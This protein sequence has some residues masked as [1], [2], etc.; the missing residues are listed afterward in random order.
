MQCCHRHCF[1]PYLAEYL[2]GETRRLISYALVLWSPVLNDS[3]PG[4]HILEDGYSLPSQGQEMSTEQKW[5]LI[6]GSI[7][8]SLECNDCQSWKVSQNFSFFWCFVI[9]LRKI[10]NTFLEGKRTALEE[11]WKQ[12]RSTKRSR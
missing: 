8:E 9:K 5:V 11:T 7:S 10:R 12:E 1:W 4:L 2:V 3:S 6:T